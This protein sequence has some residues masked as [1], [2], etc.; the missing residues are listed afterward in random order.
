[1]RQATDSLETYLAKKELKKRVKK[2][3]MKKTEA[4]LQEVVAKLKGNLSQFYC[5]TVIYRKTIHEIQINT[6]T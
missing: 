5:M 4:R 6:A 1:M 2:K 3:I